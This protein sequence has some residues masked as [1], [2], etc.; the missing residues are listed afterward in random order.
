MVIVSAT[1]APEVLAHIAR[2]MASRSPSVFS[3][4]AID[5]QVGEGPLVASIERGKLSPS[6]RRY[7]DSHIERHRAH[8]SGQ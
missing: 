6:L 7:V 1:H 4:K 8:Q 3:G 5:G 2:A